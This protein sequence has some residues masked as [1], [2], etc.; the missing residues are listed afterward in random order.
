[1]KRIVFIIALVLLSSLAFAFSGHIS[2][3]TVW[4]SDILITGDVWIDTDITLTIEAGVTVS[5]LRIDI[6]N[7]GTG[8]TDFF[9]NGQ[10]LVSGTEADPVI[11]TSWESTPQA[12]DW[13]GITHN[14]T[15][16][17][18][19]TISHLILQYAGKGLTVNGKYI[20]ISDTT[21]ENCSAEGVY[22]QN[23]YSGQ[24]ALTNVVVQ[25]NG[26][27]GV[28]VL[29]NGILAA[30]NLFSSN[31][32]DSGI[33]ITTTGNVSIQNSRFVSNAM[34]GAE[35]SNANVSITNSALSYNDV[36][37]MF[38][39]DTT[40]GSVLTLSDCSI[41]DN[42]VVGFQAKGSIGGTAT[43]LQ[44]KRN[45]N[46][47]LVIMNEATIAFSNCDISDNAIAP[48]S[49]YYV[50]TIPTNLLYSTGSY[51]SYYTTLMPI[52]NISGI[53]ASGYADHDGSSDDY[54]LYAYDGLG[55]NFW[56]Y[57]RVNTS[58]D[59]NFD[60]WFN[61]NST[62]TNSQIRIYCSGYSIYSYWG[63]ITEIEYDL[64]T[65]AKQ[66]I[67]LNKTASI[68][69]TNNWWGTD[70]NIVN[71]LFIATAG[72]ADYSSPLVAIP[73]CGA[74][75]ANLEPE[76][77]LLTPSELTLT[78]TTVSLT[79]S[80]YDLDD[81]AIIT[82]GYTEELGT[83]GTEIVSSIHEDS[84]TD[85]YSWNVST[86]PHGLYYIYGIIDDGIN[87]PV[88]VYAPERVMVGPVASKAVDS[89]GESGSQVMVPV[90]ITN[91]HSIF[92]FISWQ[93]TMVYDPT[94][95][96]AV[97]V[98]QTGTLSE[99]WSVN[100]NSSIPGQIDVNGYNVNPLTEDGT[101][102]NIVFNVRTGA[103][104][105]STGNIGFNG[106]VFNDGAIPV[107][108]Q[109]GV[110][111]VRNKYVL[112]GNV[113]YFNQAF[114]MENITLS[115][116]GIDEESVSTLANGTYTFPSMYAGDYQL[117]VA[118]DNEVPFLTVTPY[119]ASIT[120]QY[121]LNTWA[122]NSYQIKAADVNGDDVTDAFDSAL[123]IQYAINLI[124]ELPAGAWVFTPE[125]ISLTLSSAYSRDF[126]AMAVG[127]PS[128]N[129][130]QLAGRRM[131]E[132]MLVP[133]ITDREGV[134]FNA[135]CDQPFYST[136]MKL[137]YNPQEL[138]FTNL[139]SNF[140]ALPIMVNASTP[141]ELYIGGFSMT[142]ISTE[143]PVFSVNFNSLSVQQNYVTLDYLMFDEN[144]SGSLIPTAI[145]GE[146]NP[147]TQTELSANFPNPFN[148]ETT[149]S[150]NLKS[151]EKTELSIY[152]QKG[153]L[154]TTL[155][156]DYLL[157]GIHNYVWKGV[158]TNG[159]K[160]SSGVYFYRLQAG[161]YT[162]TRKMILMK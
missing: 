140:E 23:S 80:D 97:N 84:T 13:N 161:T 46:T 41:N 21:I 63:R 83:A 91:A 134:R 3:N 139:T 45:G 119:D 24:T 12:G 48:Q 25:N 89:F 4:S 132:P 155:V 49:F 162:K 18:Y 129:Y 133:L 122:F 124:P 28:S 138:E 59:T 121:A 100:Y 135:Y 71:Q 75:L 66:A 72:M 20:N 82:L 62:S 16:S 131:P 34:Y 67:I 2:Q 109:S 42:A 64:A 150:F 153:Q 17:V 148:P 33:K 143:A 147:L 10:L 114:P 118:S 96:T 101:L 145:E 90:N 7:D 88:T 32:A 127:D 86:V 116:V 29:A 50:E 85:A 69:L 1:M 144:F 107:T 56:T 115:A 126:T 120:A 157:P 77:S 99:G 106:F 5:F 103:S 68:S 60:T 156:D 136:G 31:N 38:V 61:I 108:Q 128:G 95:L 14:N 47:G 51:T 79:W 65:I 149:I 104:D 111:T 112:S 19:S 125:N 117:S 159:K 40:D 44:I 55:A 87:S 15:A 123:M 160:V 30:N 58:S 158:D 11:F 142:E 26:S 27:D 9:V 105:F 53:H 57:S 70:E 98:S 54:Y 113:T 22:I 110:F 102:I 52:N 37:G 8:D 152:N 78:P 137:T 39:E 146:V 81:D 154:V 43:N 151:G 36:N 94:L 6:A 76:L 35:I 92:G 93:M 130:A 141:G 73:S 74:T